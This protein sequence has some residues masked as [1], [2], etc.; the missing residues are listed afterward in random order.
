MSVNPLTFADYNFHPAGAPLGDHA[1]GEIWAAA[2][3][4]MNWLLIDKYGYDPD[5]TTGYVPGNGPGGAGNKLALQLVSDGLKLQP[6]NPTFI[7]AR[8]AILLADRNLPGG[9]NQQSIWAAFAR[10][11]LGYGASVPGNDPDAAT[12]SASFAMP[13]AA[14][15]PTVVAQSPAG[16]PGSP[17]ATPPDRITVTFSTPMDP[18]S[19]DPTDDIVSFVGPGGTDL[20]PSA[21]ARGFSW[22]NPHTLQ[23]NFTPPSGPEAQGRYT[24]VLAPTVLSTTGGSLDQ[25]FNGAAGEA[26]DRY[27]AYFQFD[28]VPLTVSAAQ[29]SGG[30][31]LLVGAD[32]LVVDYNEPLDPSGVDAGNV[33][34]SQGTVTG[35]TILSPTRVAY[36]LSGL[37]KGTLYL[38]IKYGAVSDPYGF[39]VRVFH[40][41]LSV[42]VAPSPPVTPPLTPPTSPPVSPPSPPVSPPVDS[43]GD[44]MTPDDGTGALPDDGGAVFLPIDSG[45]GTSSGGTSG[46]GTTSPDFGTGTGAGGGTTDPGGGDDAADPVEGGS[47]MDAGFGTVGDGAGDDAADD[48][49]DDDLLFAPP[50]DD[51][52]D[53]EFTDEEPSDSQDGMTEVM[54]LTVEPV[55]VAP[56]PQPLPHPPA[57]VPPTDPVPT[58]P[59]WPT[60]YT[61]GMAL[62]APTAYPTMPRMYRRRAG[63]RRR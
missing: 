30:S 22:L 59:L 19:F 62:V 10:R 4:D 15:S 25:N 40:Q 3:W 54:A 49:A 26:A 33:Q 37:E 38:S 35:F 52:D 23:I 55:A 17:S 20:K 36:S 9:Q 5:L 6:A 42:D 34:V 8:D 45:G 12:V 43:T 1:I 50:D 28:A 61:S 63:R 21:V 11:G 46:T 2:L 13:P 44:G 7:E 32:T 41:T 48:A 60:V 53:P 18:A 24:L 16:L 31:F 56:A 58:Y 27:A 39:P 29:P 14:A 57:Y 47:E 51:E